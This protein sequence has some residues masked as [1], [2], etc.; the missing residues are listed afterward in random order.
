[1]EKNNTLLIV[2]GA[3]LLY[4]LVLHR[5]TAVYAGGA[6]VGGAPVPKPITPKPAIPNPSTSQILAA[7]AINAAP[8]IISALGSFFN[9]DD[10]DSFDSGDDEYSYDDE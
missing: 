7:G 5:P 1:M 8:Q 4:F 6:G 2:G 10:S 9:S 3:V